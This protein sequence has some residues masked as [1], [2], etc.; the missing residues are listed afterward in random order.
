MNVLYRSWARGPT[1]SYNMGSHRFTSVFTFAL[2]LC[3]GHVLAAPPA[4]NLNTGG[5]LS[6]GITAVLVT[7][8]PSN[9]TRAY[10][11]NL[12]YGASFDDLTFL[13]IDTEGSDNPV[14]FGVFDAVGT[15]IA[16]AQSRGSGPDVPPSAG[17]LN[18]GQVSFGTAWRPS[19]GNGLPYWGQEGDISAGLYYVIVALPG[20][21]FSNG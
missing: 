14:A 1:G 15:L 20:S 13:D 7:L 21:T 18:A 10:S 11:F 2:S 17:L 6:D 5:Y 12:E 8:G 9:A 4:I 3:V 19:V 16:S